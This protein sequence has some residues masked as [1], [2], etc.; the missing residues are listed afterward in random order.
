MTTMRYRPA[1]AVLCISFADIANLRKLAV[2]L[3]DGQVIDR[4][5]LP[6]ARVLS[7]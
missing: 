6:A 2:V 1:F 5:A 4:G 7:R 3:R